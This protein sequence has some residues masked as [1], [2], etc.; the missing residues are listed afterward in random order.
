MHPGSGPCYDCDVMVKMFTVIAALVMLA[1]CS[2]GGKA[3][4]AEKPD[5]QF[6]MHVQALESGDKAVRRKAFNYLANH[7]EKGLDAIRDF[8]KRHTDNGWR[9]EED[10]LKCR[11]SA[12]PILYYEMDADQP[13]F[14]GNVV[15]GFIAIDLKNVGPQPLHILTHDGGIITNPLHGTAIETYLGDEPKEY[16]VVHE[17]TAPDKA[18]QIG[19]G[20]TISG[21]D[22]ACDTRY[23]NWADDEVVCFRNYKNM[24]KGIYFITYTLGIFREDT[25]VSYIQSNRIC[26]ALLPAKKKQ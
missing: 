5:T 18:V 24:G 17:I 14:K 8:C 7:G 1:G 21:K 6:K 10:G 11:I 13:V 15:R 9:K 4:P 22:F 25:G 19:E 3:V 12:D 23:Y 20:E 26:L 16:K 2:G